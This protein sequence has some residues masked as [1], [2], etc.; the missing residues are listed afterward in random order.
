MYKINI[1]FFLILLARYSPAQGSYIFYT[2]V[3]A[4][5]DIEDAMGI[6]SPITSSH[7]C[8]ACQDFTEHNRIADSLVNRYLD[9]YTFGVR[10]DSRGFYR[11]TDSFLKDTR[12]LFYTKY[13]NPGA[14]YQ[15]LKVMI[16]PD[17][18]ATSP[19]YKFSKGD[20]AVGTVRYRVVCTDCPYP[21]KRTHYYIFFYNKKGII[22]RHGLAY[23][24]NGRAKTHIHVQD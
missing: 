7:P 20:S 12:S 18:N 22:V 23:L 16:G 3:K 14:T 2:D 13:A 10:Y 11:V 19:E 4:G 8:Y 9:G 15:Y 6:I 21:P 5:P 24:K 17:Q 1:L